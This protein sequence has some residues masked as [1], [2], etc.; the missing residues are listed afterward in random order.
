MR[1]FSCR[2]SLSKPGWAGR[3]RT[4]ECQVQSLVPYQL[5][6]RPAH[7]DSKAQRPRI[8]LSTSSKLTAGETPLG[9][10]AGESSKPIF[11]DRPSRYCA[12]Q[13]R[14]EPARTFDFSSLDAGNAMLLMRFFAVNAWRAEQCTDCGFQANSSSDSSLS[15]VAASTVANGARLRIFIAAAAASSSRI[16]HAE[17]RAAAAGHL[18][19]ARA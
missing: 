5:G 8:S 7:F 14:G 12:A 1:F 13:C 9:R 19:G 17:D 15:V 6:D 10:S 18:R 11:T 16:E 4:F 2:R 3:I